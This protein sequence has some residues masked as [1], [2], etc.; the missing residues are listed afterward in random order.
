MEQLRAILDDPP[1]TIAGLARLRADRP[2]LLRRFQSAA[3][4]G[5]PEA[6]EILLVL[7][8]VLVLD[9]P[10]EGYARLLER[11]VQLAP[12]CDA[13]TQADVHRAHARFW[14]LRGRHRIAWGAAQRAR[15]ARGDTAARPL[16][17]A[18]VRFAAFH[19]AYGV[20]QSKAAEIEARA[21]LA[22]ARSTRL[23]PSALRVAALAEQASS[24]MAVTRGDWDRARDAQQEAID[25][26]RRAGA[27]RTLAIT[28]ANQGH[29]LAALGD[30]D[31]A[32]ISMQKSLTLFRAL[33][34]RIHETRVHG[35]LLLL[36]GAPLDARA[37]L[38]A[39]DAAERCGDHRTSASFS[40]ALM[41]RADRSA[42]RDRAPAL[43][44]RAWTLLAH[45]DAPDLDA[46]AR[47]L[48]GAWDRAG[49]LLLVSPDGRFA[50][51][52][53]TAIDLRARKALP[54]V[55]RALA[56]ARIERPGDHLDVA[57]VFEAGWPG[58]KAL[59]HAASARVYMA[60]RALRALGLRGAI[61]TSPAG[62][63][64]DPSLEVRWLA[65]APA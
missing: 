65:R 32:A 28:L 48:E 51:H 5:A 60:V 11:A 64:I 4:R 57:A 15:D 59:A 35:E 54:G 3:K 38:D 21:L 16:S 2:R 41:E 9:A 37:L 27:E 14:T 33:G 45:V 22:L 56:G 36:A 19:A 8:P 47:R 50:Q 6:S 31:A 40:I 49:A 61:S 23:L 44:A 12:G 55:L 42:L 63:R 53:T 10:H 20:G 29:C 62:Y 43:L 1:D 18:L 39:A 52:G 25:L 30:R 7:D 24:L 13:D 26:A 17:A 58:E 34:D 46:R